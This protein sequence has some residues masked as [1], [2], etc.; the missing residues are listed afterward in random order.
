MPVWLIPIL[1][2]LVSLL[3]ALAVAGGSV[4]EPAPRDDRPAR[5]SRALSP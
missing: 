1:Y 5:S 4:I 3:A 2:T